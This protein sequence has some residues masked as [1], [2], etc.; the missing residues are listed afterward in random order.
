MHACLDLHAVLSS[1][2]LHAVGKRDCLLG[3]KVRV[4]NASSNAVAW[5]N[6]ED[7]VLGGASGE[8][9]DKCLKVTLG[10]ALRQ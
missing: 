6:L 3:I 8:L 4:E 1:S 10:G 7:I 2:V 5:L 9:V